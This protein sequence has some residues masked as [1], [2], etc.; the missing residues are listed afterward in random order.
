MCSH[1]TDDQNAEAIMASVYY[2]ENIRERYN[3]QL[4][5]FLSIHAK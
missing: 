3:K 2:L 5:Y 1:D 4:E